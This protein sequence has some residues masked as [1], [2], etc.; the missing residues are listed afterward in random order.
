MAV[1]TFDD[2]LN[3]LVSD[4]ADRGVLNDLVNKYPGMKDGWLRQS[5]YSRKLDSFRAEKTELEGKA[6][7]FE[8][9][10]N[11][12]NQQFEAA[13]G[14]SDAWENWAEGNWDFDKDAPKMEVFWR[15]KAQELESKIGQD[16]TFDD[17]NK[18]IT[19]KGVVLKNDFESVLK[20]KEDEINKG[21]QGS[22]YFT[23]MLNEIS[24]EHYAEFK[25]PLKTSELVSKMNEFQTTDLK[26]AYDRFVADDRKALAEE[27]HKKEVEKIKAEAVKEAEE[28]FKSERLQHGGMPVDQE[29]GLGHLES[30]VRNIGDPAALDK[31]QLGDGTTARLAAEAYRKEKLGIAQ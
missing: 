7:E 28:K 20:G 22:A 24:N 18:F 13:K 26:A 1:N 30:K 4:E 27:A 21:F 19:D 5:D 6:T 16:M 9:K 12:I 3:S 15:E 10:F 17:I 29:V 25:K 31:A 14:K 23:V 2:V 8:N 11:Q